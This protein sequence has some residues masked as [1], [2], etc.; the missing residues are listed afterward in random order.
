[1]LKK[2][3]YLLFLIIGIFIFNWVYKFFAG[4][5][6]IYLILENKFK[7]FYIVLAHLPT[8]FFDSVAWLAFMTKRRLSLINTFIITWI[9]QTSGKFFPTGNI[10]GEFVR[11]YLAKKSGQRMIDASTTV[12]ADLVVATFSLFLIGF[13]SLFYILSITSNG[14]VN[15]GGIYFMLSLMLI[16]LACL[17]F[18]LIIRKRLISSFI[19]SFPKI[20]RLT[21]KRSTIFKILRLDYSLF[22][23]SFE[24]VK[25]IKALFFRL[26]GWVA[27]AIEIY[28]FLII[29]GVEATL[30]DVIL[31]ES[32]TSV[33]KSLAF[34]IPAGLGVQEFAFVFI[35][36]FVG[37][38][39]IISFSIAMGRRLREILVGLPALLAWYLIFRNKI[40]A[41]N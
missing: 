20:F 2:I 3:R 8:L 21:L 35:G 17:V 15:N 12:L 11:V 27:G 23:L 37:F 24:N 10:T 33:I 6:S 31:I 9:A 16:F 19:K 28:I 36:E 40:K 7:L 38:S 13:L 5:E 34:F 1:M 39:G 32:V 18:F 26:L 30:L 14:L 22:R 29:I 25:I 4:P 41:F